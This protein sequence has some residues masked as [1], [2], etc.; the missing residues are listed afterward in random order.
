M[1]RFSWPAFYICGIGHFV[2]TVLLMFAGIGAAMSESSAKESVEGI[3]A[4]SWFWCPLPMAAA[5]YCGITV[6]KGQL[7]L[8][9]FWSA[10]VG[11]MAGFIAS[12][13][14]GN[15]KR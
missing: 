4:F 6:E 5:K 3:T 2:M 1:K 13:V 10:A 9:P 11:V 14:I 15:K 7:L 8:F 12:K